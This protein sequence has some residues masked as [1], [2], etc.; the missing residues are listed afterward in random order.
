MDKLKTIVPNTSLFFVFMIVSVCLL[1]VLLRTFPRNPLFNAPHTGT[2]SLNNILTA[3]S[4]YDPET[5]YSQ[6]LAFLAAF[7]LLHLGDES[8]SFWC[9][10][11][12]MYSEKYNM[13]ALYRHPSCDVLKLML[14]HFHFLLGQV[15]NR[16]R[17]TEIDTRKLYHHY[18][19]IS[20]GIFESFL[21]L[22]I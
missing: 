17:K 15:G 14:E 5:G 6:G 2:K 10:V 3:Y 7:L 8:E 9:L 20:L 19:E 13:R 11:A 16:H 21:L 22:V 18:Y 4:I 1:F 12:L